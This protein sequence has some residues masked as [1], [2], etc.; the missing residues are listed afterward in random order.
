MHV[1]FDASFCMNYCNS[2][3]WCLGSD[4]AKML[5]GIMFNAV[6]ALVLYHVEILF[7]HQKH[8]YMSEKSLNLQWQL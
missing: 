4:I 5:N 8:S 1:N 3:V 2:S 7:P 6:N